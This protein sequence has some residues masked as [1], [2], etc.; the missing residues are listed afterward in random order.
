MSKMNKS[1]IDAYTETFKNSLT[2]T[3]IANDAL[4][5]IGHD[6]SEAGMQF[7]NFLGH[8]G[9]L[10]RER[11]ALYKLVMYLM[12]DSGVYE[13]VMDMSDFSD[14]D[15]YG[16]AVEVNDDDEMNV[17]FSIEFPESNEE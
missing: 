5:K 8:V 4:I 2:Q 13:Y 9:L 1:D 16:L 14:L 3:K 7:G 12:L 6:L 10:V 15:S 17:K 11:D